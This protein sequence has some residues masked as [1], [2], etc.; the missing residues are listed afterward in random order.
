M[1]CSEY[2]KSTQVKWGFKISSSFYSKARC[3]LPSTELLGYRFS[4]MRHR[5]GAG[6]VRSQAGM[7]HAGIT[8]MSRKRQLL[9]YWCLALRFFLT[10]PCVCLLKHVGIFFAPQGNNFFPGGNPEVPRTVG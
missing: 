10:N 7:H 9:S 1:K 5:E 4:L 3:D 6:A 2:K 8:K